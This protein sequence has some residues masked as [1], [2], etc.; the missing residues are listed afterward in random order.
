MTGTILTSKGLRLI[1]KVLASGLP[2]AFSRVAVGTGTFPE[3]YN[4][5]YAIGLNKYKMD[6][7]IS[8]T[9]S[10][11]EEATIIFQIGAQP[12]EESFIITEVGL[13]A[14]D[15]DEGEVLYA[16]LNLSSSPEYVYATNGTVQKLVEIEF[17]TIIGEVEHVSVITSP[18][19]LV[20]KEEFKQELQKKIS[21]DGGDISETIS[22]FEDY[23]RENSTPL[24]AR[25]A[26]SRIVSGIKHSKFVEYTKAAL[27]GL[28]TL[29]EMRGLLV[30]HGLCTEPGKFF[31]DAAYGKYL[32]DQIT[33][34]NSDKQSNIT[35]AASTITKNNLAANRVLISDQNGKLVASSITNIQLG[36]LNG[37]TSNIQTQL[38]NLSTNNAKL[39]KYT[40]PMI[41]LKNLNWITSY[42]G[43]KYATCGISESSLNGQIVS[44][45]MEE[46]GNWQSSLNMMLDLRNGVLEIMCNDTSILH[47]NNDTGAVSIVKIT[48]WYHA[49]N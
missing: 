37:I 8:G 16:Y 39:R 17:K 18:N 34:L 41:T 19:A 3:G 33:Q 23:T 40:S 20:T 43:K 7:E 31:L 30:N 28:V 26:I 13:F 35:G 48:V 4:P 49:N 9:Y 10:N 24:D 14:Q 44:F 36:Y 42:G 5:F 12:I 1:T 38:N 11:G 29:G 15:P 47:A 46:F 21:H 2:L 45:Y 22:Q 27:M 6:G 32:T 25:T